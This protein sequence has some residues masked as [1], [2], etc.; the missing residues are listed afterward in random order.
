MTCIDVITS[1]DGDCRSWLSYN[2]GNFLVKWRW[3]TISSV[4][5]LATTGIVSATI[6][7][8][9]RGIWRTSFVHIHDWCLASASAVL[10]LPRSTVGVVFFY[11][12]G[13]CTVWLVLWLQERQCIS[14]QI[15]QSRVL[16]RS[17][18]GSHGKQNRLGKVFNKIPL[19]RDSS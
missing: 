19:E 1:C 3:W 17:L 11:C 15:L 6:V 18:V 14:C 12:E 4:A 13:P 7:L 9:W 5:A 16:F 8:R 2:G 10:L